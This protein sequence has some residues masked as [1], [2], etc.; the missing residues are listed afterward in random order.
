VGR[1]QVVLGD[2]RVDL[3]RSEVGVTQHGLDRA[4][5]RAA[6]EK[7]GRERMPQLVWR[8]QG[9]DPCRHRVAPDHSPEALA[10]E[11]PGPTRGD[12]ERSI[13]RAGVLRAHVSQVPCGMLERDFSYRH[14]ALLSTLSARR[15]D[16][17][18]QIEVGETQRAKF[19]HAQTGRVHD[20]EHRRMKDSA[21]RRDVRSREEALDLFERQDPR[22]FSSDLG[23]VEE[24][25]RVFC[26]DSFPN[27][28]LEKSTKGRELARA[29]PGAESA[30][31]VPHHKR[32]DCVGHELARIAVIPNMSDK[33]LKITRICLECVARKRALHAKMVE[34]RVDPASQAHT[35]QSRRAALRL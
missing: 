28:E 32:G 30:S 11:T 1:P 23:T 17:A 33:G 31:N 9:Y 6:A 13:V 8:G 10:R 5:I 19:A 18:L 26:Q 4:K 21:V 16:S 29:R 25:G 2:V 24:S 22:Q 20:V 34:I 15:D 35:D 3:G 27:E 14:E 12:E 7:M